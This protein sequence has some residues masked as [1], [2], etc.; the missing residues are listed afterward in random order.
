MVP[1]LATA[2]LG[3][4]LVATLNFQM[5]TYIYFCRFVFYGIKYIKIIHNFF[6]NLFQMAVF[7]KKSDNRECLPNVIYIEEKNGSSLF[8]LLH[9]RKLFSE[10]SMKITAFSVNYG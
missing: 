5:V 2:S 1:K 8:Q 3:G 4:Q 9:S 6:K 10:N 7:A